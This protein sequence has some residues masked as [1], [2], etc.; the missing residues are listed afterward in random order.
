[1]NFHVLG[2]DRNEIT[3]NYITYCIFFIFQVAAIKWDK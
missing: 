2:T 3:Y 1:M